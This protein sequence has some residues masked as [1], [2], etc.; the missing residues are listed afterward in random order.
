[1]L[2]TFTRESLAAAG[3]T[4]LS[5]ELENGRIVY[6]PRCPIELPDE[7]E[8]TFLRQEMPKH[9]KLKNISYHP[10]AG[11]IVGAKGEPEAIARVEKILRLHSQRVDEF[12][13][14]TIPTL[15][16][17]WKVGTSSYRPLQER[18]RALS[19]RAS[20]ELVHVDAGA[21]GATHGD[22]VLRFFVNLNPSEDRVW[23]SKGAFPELYRKYGRAAGILPKRPS[24]D[25]LKEG[26]VDRLYT[27]IVDTVASAFP[28]A[29]MADTSPYD[30]LMRRF[31]NYM[32]ETRE[33]QETTDGHV[34]FE[35]KPFSSWMVFTDMVSHACISGQH[36]FVDTFVIPLENC[37][38]KEMAPFYVLKGEVPRNGDGA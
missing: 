31:H 1:M 5:D 12:L 28:L 22:R 23:I 15:A 17:N 33:F 25:R 11:R 21:Y 10:E 18:G 9:V 30:R 8:L 6:F 3:P 24:T 37:R 26:T 2:A 35:F 36:A 19:V 14:R 16:K 34:Q 13:K 7:A 27:G 29:K 32:K 38:V 20:N 4:T